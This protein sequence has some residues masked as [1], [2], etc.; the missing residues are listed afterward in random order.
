MPSSHN[1]KLISHID[2][3]GGG[4]VWVDGDILYIGH[5]EA[6]SGTSILDISDPRKPK[7][8]FVRLLPAIL[9][10]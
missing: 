3:P 2:C 8:S 5:M 4:Q 10:S 7:P 1:A 9:T 6:P